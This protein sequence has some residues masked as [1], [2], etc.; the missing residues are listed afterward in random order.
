MKDTL[1]LPDKPSIAVLPFENMSRDPDQEYFADGMTEDIITELSRFENLFVIARNTSFVYKGQRVDVKKIANELG[2]HFILEGSVRKAGQR[3]RI[4][5][6][7]INGQDGGHVWAERYDGAL[8][9][10]FDLQ[11]QVTSQVVS[12]ISPQ[13]NEAELEWTGRR[14]RKFDVAHELA[15]SAQELFR[16]GYSLTDPSKVDQAIA[17]ATEAVA[18]NSKCGIAYQTICFAYVLQSLY[19]WGD[20][21]SAAAGLAEDWAKKFHS[22]LQNSYMAF[23]CLGMARFRSGQYPLIANRCYEAE[24]SGFKLLRLF[25]RR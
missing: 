5:A 9:D 21:P 24:G 22:Q 3:V 7:L 1:P 10:V 16:S 17:L 20:D 25:H 13:I 23:C 6:Q 18:M 11:E 14:E 19:R 15:W 4:T 8:E 2:I 12:A